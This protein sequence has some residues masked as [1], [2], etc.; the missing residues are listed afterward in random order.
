[1]ARGTINSVIMLEK[2]NWIADGNW[3]IIL[4]NGNVTFF[5]IETT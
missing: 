3:S 4:D 2:N 5:E 1:V